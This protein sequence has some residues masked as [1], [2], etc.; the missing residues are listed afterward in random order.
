MI[1]HNLTTHTTVRSIRL[2]L[3]PVDSVVTIERKLQLPISHLKLAVGPHVATRCH[4][5]CTKCS[6]TSYVWMIISTTGTTNFEENRQWWVQ[7]IYMIL[8]YQ[9]WYYYN[10]LICVKKHFFSRFQSVIFTFSA[11][12]IC[13][14]LSTLK[15]KTKSW[16]LFFCIHP[17]Q[18]D[19]H[20]CD[21]LSS[22]FTPQ[23]HERWLPVGR[24]QH[25]V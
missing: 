8:F 6:M 24:K 5:L 17:V 1:I 15:K 12:F 19:T 14:D 3:E 11:L 18:L 20:R 25:P 22:T 23:F 13:C 2:L 10:F 9:Y 21:F 4:C 16:N 7:G